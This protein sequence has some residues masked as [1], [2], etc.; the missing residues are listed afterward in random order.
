[1]ISRLSRSAS[2]WTVVSI[3][4]F[5]SSLS[6]SQRLSMAWTKPFTPVSGDRSSWATAAT[7]SDRSRSRRGST[8]AGADGD[9]HARGRSQRL[10]APDPRRDQALVAVG[11]HPGLL[12]DA[13][14]GARPQERRVVLQPRTSVVAGQREHVDE[15]RPDHLRA[16]DAEQLLRGPVDQHHGL[17]AVEDDDAVGQDVDRLAALPLHVRH[18]TCR[19]A[20]PVPPSCASRTVQLRLVSVVSRVTGGATRTYRR[21]NS[22]RTVSGGGGVEAEGGGGGEVEALGA[23]VDGDADPVVGQGGDLGREAPGLVAE[24]PGRTPPPAGRRRR[25]GRSRR[26]RR[27]RARSVRR[28]RAAATAAATSGSTTTGRWKRLPTLA[29]TVLGL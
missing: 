15:L 20:P 9:G 7:R 21:R 25:R 24:Q 2:A 18:P 13:G 19:V 3:S 23:A 17:V 26:R 5:C 28:A 6:W 16:V 4:S 29:R 8:A 12:G 22:T 27:R 11:Q 1:M 14:A 10:V